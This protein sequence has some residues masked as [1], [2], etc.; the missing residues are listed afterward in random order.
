M[1]YEDEKCEQMHT[2]IWGEKK[3]LG[4]P[5]KP[6]RRHLALAARRLGKRGDVEES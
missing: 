3:F 5:R 2:V 6:E 4:E 1:F